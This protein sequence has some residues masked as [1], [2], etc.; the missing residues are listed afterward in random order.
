MPFLSKAQRNDIFRVLA[1]SKLGPGECEFDGTDEYNVLIRHVST[2][3]TVIIS[4]VEVARKP[5]YCLDSKV[6]DDPTLVIYT[7]YAFE[8]V[9]EQVAF[10]ADAVWEWM[11]TPDLWKLARSG[12]KIP[13]ELTPDSEN[14][15]FFPDEQAAMA[16][17]LREIKE[18]IKKTHELTAEQSKHIDEKFVEAEKASRRMGRKDWG[19]FFGGALLSLILSDTITPAIMGDILM[20][21]QHGIGHL[22]SGPPVSGVLSAGQG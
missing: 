5:G 18:A 2:G 12:E 13:G 10:W 15:P 14:T 22:F 6:G 19:M 3:S 8:K 16:A 11:D 9:V 17:Q 4:L 1:A 21:V 7:P 20:M